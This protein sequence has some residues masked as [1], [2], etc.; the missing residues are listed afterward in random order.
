VHF[1]RGQFEP[2][3]SEFGGPID[4][5]VSVEDAQADAGLSVLIDDHT[6]EVDVG[7]AEVDLLDPIGVGGAGAACQ[8]YLCGRLT[9]DQGS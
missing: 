3:E 8:G 4:R 1:R 6:Y 9:I 2:V 5:W 7:W